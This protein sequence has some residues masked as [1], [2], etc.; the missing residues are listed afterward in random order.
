MNEKML[1]KIRELCKRVE[2]GKISLSRLENNEKVLIYMW[3]S[4]FL[5]TPTLWPDE[6]DRK[7]EKV[8]GLMKDEDVQ[9][10]AL[11]K[12][13]DKCCKKGRLKK[14][15]AIVEAVVNVYGFG[16]I[17]ET[18][19]IWCYLFTTTA[20]K[21]RNIP[22]AEKLKPDQEVAIYQDIE[23][24]CRYVAV[25][26]DKQ[27]EFEQTHKVAYGD[28]KISSFEDRYHNTRKKFFS[29][30]INGSQEEAIKK[31]LVR[32]GSKK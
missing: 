31:V 6:R 4:S 8:I 28:T 26:T 30:C 9:K 18:N 16:A 32:S 29:E 13:V 25:A 10:Y 7:R 27:K 20:D 19:E 11:Q 2:E 17:K 3:N 14:E 1:K 24:S 5:D 15:T 23:N 21:S 22:G 12:S